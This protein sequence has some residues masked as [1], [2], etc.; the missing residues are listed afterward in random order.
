MKRFAREAVPAFWQERDDRWRALPT[1]DQHKRDPLTWEHEKETLAAHFH[2]NVRRAPA[3]SLCAY[4]D[5]ELQT[6]SP[7]TVDHF[8]P[9][10]Q[11]PHLAICWTNLFPACVACNSTYKRAQWAATLLRPDSDAVDELIEF[12]PESGELRPSPTLD[13]AARVRVLDTIRI[14]GL[15]EGQRPE[16]RRRVWRTLW[17]SPRLRDLQAVIEHS[18]EGPYRFIADAIRRAW[19]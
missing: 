15:N 11:Q 14:F 19:E 13:A 3:P 1:A 7:E 18:R 9:R 12:D 5:G 8:E 4:C 2:R 16:A 6:Q 10:S 17:K